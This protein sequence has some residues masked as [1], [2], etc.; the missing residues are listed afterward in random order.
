MT[1]VDV[2]DHAA[3]P[4]LLDPTGGPGPFGR[5][6]VPAPPAAVG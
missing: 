1:V 4:V 3:P 6:R 5:R 2:S